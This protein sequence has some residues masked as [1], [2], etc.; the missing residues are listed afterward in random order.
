MTTLSS[1]TTVAITRATRLL[2]LLLLP[3][4]CCSHRTECWRHQLTLPWHHSLLACL[5]AQHACC[6]WHLM[7]HLLPDLGCGAGPGPQPTLP[8]SNPQ[9]L[10]PQSSPAG[11][12]NMCHCS[13]LMLTT[14]HMAWA[15]LLWLPAREQHALH[16]P[17]QQH[18]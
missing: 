18:P 16:V 5:Q 12:A 13:P 3:V 7:G 11:R 15:A 1:G 6:A 14:S 10:S 8:T 4:H 9:C 2:L 17:A